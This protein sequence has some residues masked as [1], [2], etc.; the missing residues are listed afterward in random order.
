MGPNDQP[1]RAEL[2]SHC[3]PCCSASS[4]RVGDMTRRAFVGGMGAA[5]IGGAALSGLTWSALVANENP[6]PDTASPRRPLKVAPLLLYGVPQRQPQTSWRS[7]GG[8]QCENDATDEVN[9]ISRELAELQQRADFPV[10]FAPVARVRTPAELDQVADLQQAD[11]V[12]IYA[13][14]GWMEALDALGKM[15]KDLIIFCRHK[16]GPVYLWYEIISPRYLRQHTD[17]RAVAGVDEQDVVIDCQD[18]L[19]WRLR[20]VRLAQHQGDADRGH[21]GRGRLGPAGRRRAETGPRQMEVGHSGRRLCSIGHNAQG[22]SCGIRHAG[23]HAPTNRGLP[24]VA[25]HQTGN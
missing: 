8:I 15:N 22:R 25:G 12:I 1:S 19:L 18:A 3:C 21:R 11:T 24:P 23:P 16:S 4:A 9:R 14:G 5:T 17:K 13:A 6:L 20:L 2:H 7:W 10:Q